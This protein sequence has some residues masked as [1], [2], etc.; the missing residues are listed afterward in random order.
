[1]RFNSIDKEAWISLAIGLGITLFVILI[2]FFSYVF[3]YL[4]TLVHELGHTVFGWLYGY[5]SIPAFDFI[6][7]GGIT[8]HQKRIFIIPIIVILLFCVLIYLLRKNRLTLIILLI[9]GGLYI[10]TALT[11]IHRLIILSAGHGAELFFA[12]LFLYRALSN[13][14]IIIKAERPLYAFLSLFIFVR[15][16][17]FANNLMVNP[18]FRQQYAAAKGGGHWM[19]FSRIAREYLHVELSVIAHIFLITCLIFPV[20]TFL[21]FRYKPYIDRFLKKVTIIESGSTP[22]TEPWTT[23]E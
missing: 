17:R 12:A 16:Y 6:Y 9:L 23:N 15:D 22:A 8:I 20:L 1:M 13:H 2:P 19:D 21:F 4:V 3:H 11:S 7:G 5:P 10:L 14:A 18:L